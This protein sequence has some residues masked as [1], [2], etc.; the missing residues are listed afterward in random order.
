MNGAARR[1]LRTTASRRAIKTATGMVAVERQGVLSRNSVTP[2]TYTSLSSPRLWGNHSEA[3]SSDFRRGDSGVQAGEEAPLLCIERK[4]FL[5]L[6][7]PLQGAALTGLVTRLFRGGSPRECHVPASD[8]A[9][10]GLDLRRFT[11][12]QH[13]PALPVSGTEEASRSG[14][15][16]PVH[17]VV[18]RTSPLHL[19]WSTQLLSSHLQAPPFRTG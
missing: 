1:Q 8:L 16:P 9:V 2:D 19:P 3:R 14:S 11:F 5:P 18:R 15:C 13:D 10:S 12:R 4:P 17:D 6:K 7:M